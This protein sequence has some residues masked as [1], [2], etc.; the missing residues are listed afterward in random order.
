MA[1]PW[2]GARR[3]GADPSSLST[4]AAVVEAVRG[5]TDVLGIIPAVDVQPSVRALAV[6]GRSL[7]GNG[8]DPIARGVAAHVPARHRPRARG[9]ANA[10]RP[11]SDMDSCRGR[12]RHERPRGLSS[13]RPARRRAGLPMGRR[14]G[15]RSSPGRAAASVSPPSRRNGR[16]SRRRARIVHRSGRLAREPR[17]SCSRPATSTIRTGS[18]SRS[19]RR[20]RPAFA[21][22][23][24]TSCR[25]RTTT[26]ATPARTG[27]SRRSGTSRRRV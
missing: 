4:P 18:S 7:F 24:S 9:R 1:A 19:I 20:S 12:R 15:A 17:R 3:P 11:D 22:P 10:V 5:T 25:W 2:R 21:M 8:R 16:G 27:S 13:R 26:S 14:H 23:A 6:D